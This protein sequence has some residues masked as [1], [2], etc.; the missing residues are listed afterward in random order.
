MLDL[1]RLNFDFL[2]NDLIFDQFIWSVRGKLQ[3]VQEV[4]AGI[5]STLFCAALRY[6][7]GHAVLKLSNLL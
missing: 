3:C 7:K 1:L 5:Q 6:L 2:N 4:V